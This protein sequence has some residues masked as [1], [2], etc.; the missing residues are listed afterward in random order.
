MHC[1][2]AEALSHLEGGEAVLPSYAVASPR[3]RAGGT[4][5]T[6]QDVAQRRPGLLLANSH[7]CCAVPTND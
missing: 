1:S 4:Q 7:G 2:E 5:D 3:L 6:H